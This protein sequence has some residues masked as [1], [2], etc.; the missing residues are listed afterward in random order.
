MVLLYAYWIVIKIRT[1]ADFALEVL[2]IYWIA[3]VILMTGEYLKYK[4][5]VQSALSLLPWLIFL[6]HI[7]SQ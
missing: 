2:F 3:D 6:P 4:S 1:I 7:G 5:S